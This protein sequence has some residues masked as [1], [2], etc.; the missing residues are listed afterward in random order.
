MDRGCNKRGQE[1]CKAGGMYRRKYINIVHWKWSTLPTCVVLAIYRLTRIV[2]LTRQRINSVA[3]DTLFILDLWLL[4]F[5]IYDSYSFV[6]LLYTATV[7][8]N[9]DQV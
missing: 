3:V 4:T 8:D 6:H 9:L 7:L 1:S 2:L 5:Y